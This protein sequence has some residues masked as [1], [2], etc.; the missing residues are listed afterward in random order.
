MTPIK[1]NKLQLTTPHS[2]TKTVKTIDATEKRE[3]LGRLCRALNIT[4]N[5]GIFFCGFSMDQSSKL[6]CPSKVRLFLNHIIYINVVLNSK[7]CENEFD[8][9]AI[10]ELLLEHTKSTLRELIVDGIELDPLAND[11]L[12]LASHRKDS[13]ITSSIP[14]HLDDL[15]EFLRKRLLPQDNANLLA[16]SQVLR[17]IKIVRQKHFSG[18]ICIIG[19]GPA[20]LMAAVSLHQRFP[21]KSIEII[22]YQVEGRAPRFNNIAFREEVEVKVKNTSSVNNGFPHGATIKYLEKVHRKELKSYGNKI[23]ITTVNKKYTA[24]DVSQIEAD[25]IVI[26]TGAN[27]EF[28][29]RLGFSFQQRNF[30]MSSDFEKQSLN[31]PHLNLRIKLNNQYVEQVQKKLVEL[32]KNN[33]RMFYY[34]VRKHESQRNS[35]TTTF[36]INQPIIQ[37]NDGLNLQEILE[38][39]SIGEVNID[40]SEFRITPVEIKQTNEMELSFENKKVYVIGDA[41]RTPF[42]IFAEGLSNAREDINKLLG[43]LN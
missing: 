29:E 26:A 35:G 17:D 36:Y 23:T 6:N 34:Y 14:S 20:G 1:L 16:G 5:N 25:I 24:D 31:A 22:D 38:N 18:K 33:G 13:W 11:L 30:L 37:I 42:Y 7:S 41:H 4:C 43:A 27:S 9:I 28:V 2:P 15:Y 10:R 3:I 32:I 40:I 39:L 12:T 21:G 8:A 19:S